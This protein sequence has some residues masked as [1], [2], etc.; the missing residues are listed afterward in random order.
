MDVRHWHT[1]EKSW[2]DENP[3][4]YK[5]TLGIE[6]VFGIEQITAE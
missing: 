1:P 6:L 4:R 5:C 3:P 2:S